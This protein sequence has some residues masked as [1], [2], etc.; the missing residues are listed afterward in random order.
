MSETWI[1]VA[2]SGRARIFAPREK[3]PRPLDEIVHFVGR[4]GYAGP[5]KYPAQKLDEVESLV[6]PA[7][8]M[9]RGGLETDRPGRVQA[10]GVAESYETRHRD[11]DHQMA[12]EFVKEIVEYLARARQEHR[13]EN[14]ILAAPPLFLGV[15]RKK[16]PRSLKSL[17][18]L[19]LDKDY[20]KLSPSELRAL[21]P[22]ELS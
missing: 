3:D 15:L 9:K 18:S 12:D 11:F 22:D 21:L 1:V 6:H 14:L 5:Q 7:G 2:D 8:Q 4:A 17:V 10:P 16:L 19:E 20:T 13:F